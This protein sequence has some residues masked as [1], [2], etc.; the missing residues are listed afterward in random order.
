MDSVGGNETLFA[1]AE[2]PRRPAGHLF[3]AF[4]VEERPRKVGAQEMPSP[5]GRAAD[6]PNGTEPSAFTT[7]ELGRHRQKHFFKK[8]QIFRSL[9]T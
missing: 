3:P 4:M 1:H 2:A 7:A 5:D 8:K 9:R 6:G